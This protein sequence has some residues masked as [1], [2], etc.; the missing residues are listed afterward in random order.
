MDDREYF[1]GRGVQSTMFI[2]LSHTSGVLPETSPFHRR[3]A[4]FKG[5]SS[6]IFRERKDTCCGV[7]LTVHSSSFQTSPGRDLSNTSS[8]CCSAHN[9]S[10]TGSSKLLQQHA[11]ETAIPFA[12][13]ATSSHARSLRISSTLRHGCILGLKDAFAHASKT[14]SN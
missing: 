2:E 6:R 3:R 13:D 8:P 5:L 11:N 9:T 10:N 14:R 1:P 4:S 12:S 7:A